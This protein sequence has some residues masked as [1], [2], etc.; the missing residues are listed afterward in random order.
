M[1]MRDVQFC[2]E[3]ASLFWSNCLSWVAP[4][5]QTD[6]GNTFGSGRTHLRNLDYSGEGLNYGATRIKIEVS[7]LG[8][9]HSGTQ[10][11]RYR[12]NAARAPRLRSELASNQARD[13]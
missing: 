5:F 3:S 7:G 4:S 9:T 1:R 10:R 11:S 6:W 8:Y 2:T 12:A 13:W